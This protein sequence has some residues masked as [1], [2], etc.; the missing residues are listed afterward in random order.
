M[1]VILL[2]TE[3]SVAEEPGSVPQWKPGSATW[4]RRSL[5]QE[6]DRDPPDHLGRPTK[7]Q[8]GLPT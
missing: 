4:A 8:E 1:R 5:A 2:L 7:G 6:G 3:R